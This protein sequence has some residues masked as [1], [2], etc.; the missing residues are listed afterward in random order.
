MTAIFGFGQ[1]RSRFSE[2]IVRNLVV[3]RDTAFFCEK[4]GFL[5]CFPRFER[6]VRVG[7]KAHTKALVEMHPYN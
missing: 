5:P 1:H 3:I 4:I 7:W 6:L 2:R